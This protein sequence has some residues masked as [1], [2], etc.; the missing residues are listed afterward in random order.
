[1]TG[2]GLRGPA[3]G[4]N[5]SGAL[6]ILPVQITALS[7]WVDRSGGPDEDTSRRQRPTPSSCSQPAPWPRWRRPPWA[8]SSMR[9][10]AATPTWQ[11]ATATATA[12]PVTCGA[13][14]CYATAATTR[15]GQVA[16]GASRTSATAPGRRL[17][18]V[19]ARRHP[20]AAHRAPDYRVPQHEHP[21]AHAQ[22]LPVPPERSA[23]H[24]PL[25][26][27]SE[28]TIPSGPRT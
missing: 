19:R 24:Q 7:S 22:A 4:C 14:S 21:P 8:Y 10:K 11:R 1:M 5:G 12:E 25:R 3:T 6:C 2:F 26:S 15:T 16:S 17:A 27:A 28:T 18:G 20:V 13:G 23:P 9:R